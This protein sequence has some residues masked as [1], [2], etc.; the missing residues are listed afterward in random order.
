VAGAGAAG[1]VKVW[2]ARTGEL[3]RRLEPHDNAAHGLVFS[4]DGKLIASSGYDGLVR[5]REVASGRDVWPRAGGHGFH[6]VSLALSEKLLLSSSDDGTCRAWELPLG[7]EARRL[8]DNDEQ[9][10]R[11]DPMPVSCVSVTPD[12]RRA[13]IGRVDGTMRFVDPTTGAVRR[14][15][16][17]PGPAVITG[18]AIA[19]DGKHAFGGDEGYG[20]KL[21]SQD[22]RAED[23]APFDGP[24]ALDRVMHEDR[25]VRCV[26]L[27]PD[28]TRG[29]SGNGSH[30][31][32]WDVS[33]R[34]RVGVLQ[35][36][37]ADVTSVAFSP[38]GRD[39]CA[40]SADRTIRVWAA[41]RSTMG[42]A[43]EPTVLSGHA[44]AVEAAVFFPDGERLASSAMD[45]TIRIWS[46]RD[47]RELGRIDLGSS[48]DDAMS[49]AI[50]PDGR[51]LYA[52]TRRGVILR[53]ELATE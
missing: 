31:V 35:G 1:V 50:T 13:A 2:D 11:N 44:D 41:P 15:F 6:V 7:R 12:G 19:A 42:A 4:P 23:A 21:W 53:F 46:L 10:R 34:R 30:V 25:K 49:L 40:A 16:Q 22:E 36:F 5:V 3:V 39:L 20:V 14:V 38:T 52:G 18:V 51:S 17:P 43:R 37:K 27:S 24:V 32:E 33:S 48:F 29:L 28:G 9:H 8:L 26:A 45:R 47:A